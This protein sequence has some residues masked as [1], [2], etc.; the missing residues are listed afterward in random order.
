MPYCIIH[1]VMNI[2]VTDAFAVNP[3]D[4]DWAP[5]R[6]LG[7]LVLYDRSSPESVA[8]RC[9]EADIIVSNKTPLDA[10]ALRELPALKLVSVLATGYNVIDTIAARSAN[11]TVCNVPGYG[12]ASVAQHV[13]ALLL[14]LTNH[15]GKN[16]ASVEAG[17]WGRSADWCYTVAPVMELEGKTLGIVG[18]GHIGSRVAAIGRAL[19]MKI[20][21]CSPRLVPGSSGEAADLATVFAGSD[22][23]SLHCP[24]T[25]TNTA[26]VNRALLATMKP[27]AILVNTAR[28]GL[29]NEA[30]LA[31]ALN[32]GVIAA[33]A[34]DVLSEEPPRRPN[35]LLAARNCLVTPHNAW[36]SREARQRILLVTADN[37]RSFLA[38]HPVNVVN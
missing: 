20:L 11:V 24:L 18:Y 8:A 28:G 17:D 35:P 2:V 36:I 19:G 23:V 13:F 21:C 37:I 14:E 12:T 10:A 29:I 32:T 30:D 34:L 5:L 7:E 31:D 16:A 27:R 4:L 6:E 9:R 15:T 1:Y 25:V 38:G 26:F 3:G 22:V 33:A